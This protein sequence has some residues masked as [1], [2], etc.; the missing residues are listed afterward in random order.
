MSHDQN[1][2][3]PHNV[4]AQVNTLNIDQYVGDLINLPEGWKMSRGKGAKVAVID[5]GASNHPDLNLAGSHTFL[6][7]DDDLNGHS[8][9][10][11]GIIGAK[12][13]GVGVTGIAPDCEL[14][15]V[16]VLN[17][18]GFGRMEDVADAIRWCADEGF[19]VVS[20]S[21]G[22]FGR[23]PFM[24]KACR[25]AHEKGCTLVA[26]AG[27]SGLRNELSKPAAY[28]T[29]I[30]VAAT[31]SAKQH[32]RFSNASDEVDFAT[33]GV[34]VWSTYYSNGHYTYAQL[35]GTS[36]AC[37]VISAIAALHVA[38]AK[39]DGINLTPMDVKAKIEDMALDIDSAGFDRR[40]GHGLPVFKKGRK[41]PRGFSA[42]IKSLFTR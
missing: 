26:A 1:M 41:K 7:D 22:A 27:N 2:L 42:W 23:F 33:G 25:Y 36:M 3:L 34:D 37:P 12:A 16:K 28:D 39:A 35:S 32:A 8:T 20:L 21:L 15:T 24:D 5:T 38:H 13:D 4:D 14:W 9:H 31:D 29:V 19:D 17:A 30:A 10:C 6:R 40:T 11:C 18:M